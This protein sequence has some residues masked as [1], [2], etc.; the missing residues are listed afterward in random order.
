MADRKQFKLNKHTH[1]L[2]RLTSANGMVH[3][4]SYCFIESC[5]K[6]FHV[7]MFK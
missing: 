1:T 6:G 5:D 7:F 3:H 2:E 4:I